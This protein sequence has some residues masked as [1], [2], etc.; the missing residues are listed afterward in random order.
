MNDRT[1]SSL[2]DVTATAACGLVWGTSWYAITLQLGAVDP[3]TSLVYR[4]GLAAGLLFLWCRFRGEAVALSFEQHKAA[5]GVGFFSFTVDYGFTYFAE[6]HVV[7]GIVAVIFATLAFVN[8]VVFR[9]ALGQR[10]PR[11]AWA[12]AALGI[13]GVALLSRDEILNATVNADA[14]RGLLMALGAVVAA[15]FGNVSARQGERAGAPLQSSLAWSMAYGA[16][17]LGLFAVV[18][19][20]HWTFDF[21]A[22]YVMSLLYLAVAAS[23][24]AFVLYFGLA[25]R[26]GYTTAA[27]VLAWTPLL[28]I[29]MS[30]FF[31]DKAWGSLSLFGIALVL[32]GQWLLLRVQNSAAAWSKH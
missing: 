26:R 16:T 19:G 4:F 22:P 31:E 21:R 23:V 13:L 8:L 30:T 17:L 15:A 7:S 24:L 11:G 27:Y 10:A 28:A 6:R 29:T 3:I 2:A 5:A 20:R 12:A 9:I 25:R 18:T 14:L 1:T 32:S